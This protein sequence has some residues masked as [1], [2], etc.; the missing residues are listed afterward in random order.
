MLIKKI[1]ALIITIAVVSSCTKVPTASF[2]FNKDEYYAGDTIK[3][4]N[5]SSNAHSF[6]WKGDVPGGEQTTKDL[7]IICNR[8]GVYNIELTAYSKNGKRSNY[9]SKG[10]KVKMP[11]G[12]VVLYCSNNWMGSITV[13]VD[14]KDVGS[15]AGSLPN[16]PSCGDNGCL[17][18]TLEGGE[19]SVNFYGG[20]SYFQKTFICV[21]GTCTP[22]NLM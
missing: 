15:L 6:K 14:G 5:T 12:Q 22:V 13:V 17:T 21:S 8:S 18:L 3:I 10:I 2:T 20:G 7:Q 1:I 19:H 16:T 9:L 4:S 11:N